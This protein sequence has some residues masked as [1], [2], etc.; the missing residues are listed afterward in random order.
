MNVVVSGVF[1][2]SFRVVEGFSGSDVCPPLC[3]GCVPGFSRSCLGFC[4]ELDRGGGFFEF[5]LVS[6][7]V[8]AGGTGAPPI[9]LTS[10]FPGGLGF[11]CG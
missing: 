11:A 9:V 4:L 8:F 10:V 5:L 2:G 1:S 7:V 6:C 3:L